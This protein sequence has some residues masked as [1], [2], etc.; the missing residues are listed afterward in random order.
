[1]SGIFNLGTGRAQAF[2]DIAIA[3]VNGCR[4]VE[5]K[6]ALSLAQLHAQ[7]II[8]YVPFPDALKGRYQSFTCADISSLRDAGYCEQ[9]LDVAAGVTQY[10]EHLLSRAPV[11]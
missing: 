3:V 10:C 9:F 11:D 2:N 5:G 4:K 1:L 8:E 6:A 7:G